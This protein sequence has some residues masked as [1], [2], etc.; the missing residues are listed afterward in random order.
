[1]ET[2]RSNPS[3]L[4]NV[5]RFVIRAAAIKKLQKRTLL[6]KWGSGASPSRTLMRT[7]RISQQRVDG[8]LLWFIRP[9]RGT[10]KRQIFYLHGGAFVKGLYQQHWRFTAY[11]S[12]RLQAEVA[13]P[14]YPL[15]PNHHAIETHHAVF[16][17][18][19]MLSSRINGNPLILMG[20]SAGG[21]LALALTERLEKNSLPPPLLLV[22]LSPWLDLT[23][24]SPEIDSLDRDDPVLDREIL[25]KAGRL[26]AGKLSLTDPLVSPL[27]GDLAN[28]PP[29]ALFVGT[30]DILL[31]DS[32]RL[33]RKAAQAGSPIDLYEIT[34]LVHPGVLLPLPERSW[35]V[36]KIESIL[37]KL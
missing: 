37:T 9:K 21:G 29:T 35:I 27:Y 22:L 32:R 8:S 3:T 19:A 20:D 15:A 31:A 36:E 30:S 34:G 10:V 33:V 7:H 4:S 5:S 11:L 28:L 25:K 18:Y 23:L 26:Y 1:M 6:G 12:D 24:D 2:H 14:D 13:V 16:D 17:A